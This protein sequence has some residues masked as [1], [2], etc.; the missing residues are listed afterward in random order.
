MRIGL[1]RI[2]QFRVHLLDNGSF[3]NGKQGSLQVKAAEAGNSPG[4]A[5]VGWTAEIRDWHSR[6]IAGV[7]HAPVTIVNV[8]APEDKGVQTGIGAEECV[9]FVFAM[10]LVELKIA[11][12]QHIVDTIAGIK[13]KR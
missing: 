11:V 6:N 3:A 2:N 12:W 8:I 13:A 4:I 10:G 5:M 1:L 7:H 9:G